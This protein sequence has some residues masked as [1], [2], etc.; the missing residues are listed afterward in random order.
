MTLVDTAP[1]RTTATPKPVSPSRQVWQMFRRN[2]SAMAGLFILIAI[3]LISVIG[4]SLYSVS[5]RDM[6]WMPLTPPGES[7][8]LLGTDYLGRDLLAGS[9]IGHVDLSRLVEGGEEGEGG[10]DKSFHGA[11]AQSADPRR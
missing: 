6:V 3:V 7:E 10:V 1:V 2:H 8:Y 11:L 5:P 9:K 4:P